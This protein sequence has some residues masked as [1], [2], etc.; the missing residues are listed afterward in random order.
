MI[1]RD[2]YITHIYNNKACIDPVS[3]VLFANF[4]S[5]PGDSFVKGVYFDLVDKLLPY[6]DIP[7]CAWRYCNPPG[8]SE[9][10]GFIEAPLDRTVFD[11]H[12]NERR[13][14]PII[15]DIGM[16]IDIMKP[17][18]Y[19][20]IVIPDGK[21]STLWT[22]IACGKKQYTSADEAKMRSEI[23]AALCHPDASLKGILAPYGNWETSTRLL[24]FHE[25]DLKSL[26]GRKKDSLLDSEAWREWVGEGLKLFTL[27]MNM[28]RYM[29][30]GGQ[31]PP[32][33]E[34]AMKAA[35]KQLSDRYI[36]CMGAIRMDSAHDLAYG[37]LT[38][39]NA[40]GEMNDYDFVYSVPGYS[41]GMAFTQQQTML[42]GGKEELEG[43]GIFSAVE[44][45]KNGGVY[46]Q[47]TPD[48]NVCPPAAI[49]SMKKLVY[50]HM[51]RF[52]HKDIWQNIRFRSYRAPFDE[53]DIQFVYHPDSHYTSVILSE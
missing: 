2:K 46:V 32:E 44:P 11:V 6:V 9:G 23:I 31:L 15:Q 28:P 52:V 22:K 24:N 38:A 27:H 42:L 39:H 14:M 43:S 13:H 34:G 53:K 1:V 26:E 12:F 50:P 51:R 41:W 33:V 16:S 21:G 48:I 3:Y 5:Y 36:Y 49:Q 30:P 10:T 47:L 37:R 7:F 45:R 35:L 19:K 29:L 25:Y 18:I 17:H 4:L 40:L 8:I 20:H